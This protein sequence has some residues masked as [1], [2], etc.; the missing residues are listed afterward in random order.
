[1]TDR[2]TLPPL[3]ATNLDPVLV[4]LPTVLFVP[5][6]AEALQI[7]ESTVRAK[8]RRGEIPMGKPGRLLVV[9]RDTFIDWLRLCALGWTAAAAVMELRNRAQGRPPQPLFNPPWAPGVSV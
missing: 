2:A 6:V 4:R 7:D 5:D 3:A 9:D 8:V 1:M